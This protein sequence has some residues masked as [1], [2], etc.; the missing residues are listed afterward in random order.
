[1]YAILRESTGVDKAGIRESFL[2]PPVYE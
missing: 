2:P 1:L